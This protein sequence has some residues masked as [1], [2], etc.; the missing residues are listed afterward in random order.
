MKPRSDRRQAG[1]DVLQK[2]AQF[3]LTVAARAAVRASGINPFQDACVAATP[4][5][6]GAWSKEFG[7]VLV[8]CPTQEAAAVAQ[9]VSAWLADNPADVWAK[10]TK[11]QREAAQ[12][13]WV[14]ITTGGE[15]DA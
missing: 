14:R 7:A 11:E 1:D 10:L 13:E 15:G 9:M 3:S 12:A 8:V 5:R 2:D 6:I 4:V